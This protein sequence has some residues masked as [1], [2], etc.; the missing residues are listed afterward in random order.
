MVSRRCRHERVDGDFPFG[1]V[2][3]RLVS[4]G[5]GLEW[6]TNTLPTKELE[7]VDLVDLEHPFVGV[8]VCLKSF[9]KGV[10]W[11]P[12]GP[13]VVCVQK[14]RFGASFGYKLCMAW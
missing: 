4:F 6:D 14:T 1:W 2:P 12:I 3:M 5:Q 10:V 7:S 9:G 13:L 8:L 11:G